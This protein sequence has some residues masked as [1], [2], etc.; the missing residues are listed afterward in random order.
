MPSPCRQFPKKLDPLNS[1]LNPEFTAARRSTSMFTN[2]ILAK[3]VKFKM[4][5]CRRKT[6]KTLII[7]WSLDLLVQAGHW[8]TKTLIQWKW[9][10]YTTRYRKT[11][12]CGVPVNLSVI[13]V[14]A[15]YVKSPIKSNRFY[16]FLRL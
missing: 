4:Y 2:A 9:A 1:H 6:F 3:G 7:P 11:Q 8:G 12:T 10:D 13:Y 5:K 16:V 15:C 14:F